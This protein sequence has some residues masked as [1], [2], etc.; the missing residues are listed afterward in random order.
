MAELEGRE[1]VDIRGAKIGKI[2]R[3][4][5]HGDDDP[6]WAVVSVG[7][8]GMHSKLVPLHNVEEDDD[9]LR[10]VYEKEHVKDAPDVEMEDDRLDDEAADVL[11]GYYGLERVTGLAAPDAHDDIELSRDTRDATPP[12][13]EEGPDSPLTQ[14]RRK[15]AEELGI[16]SAQQ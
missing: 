4:C 14:R 13:L 5:A 7:I 2:E 10:V 12:G 6:Q 15:R 3:L 9:A 11:H 1:V 8:L 16:P